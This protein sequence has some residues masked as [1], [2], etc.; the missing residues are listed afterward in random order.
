M[1]FEKMPKLPKGTEEI[2]R[3]DVPTS[4]RTERARREMETAGREV[5]GSGAEAVVETI[6]GNDSKL[7]AHSFREGLEAR[8]IFYTHRVL[9]LLFPKYIPHIHA[10][11]E[12]TDERQGGTIRERVYTKEGKHLLQKLLFPQKSF[13][14]V[15]TELQRMGIEY[16]GFD[17]GSDENFKRGSDGYERY[18]DLDPYT[19]DDFIIHRDEVLNYMRQKKYSE[20]DIQQVSTSIDRLTALKKSRS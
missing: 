3:S 16:G 13:R 7:A 19:G 12:H 6:P 10:A 4:L 9:N 5:V 20:S 17:Y 1:P 15:L 2:F 18:L 14:Y 8:K 11:F